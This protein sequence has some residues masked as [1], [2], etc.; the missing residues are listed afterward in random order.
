M[1]QEKFVRKRA[2]EG[3]RAL[4]GEAPFIGEVVVVEKGSQTQMT[5]ERRKDEQE[6]NRTA[7]NRGER[8]GFKNRRSVR[9]ILRPGSTK[10]GLNR[11][12]V[13]RV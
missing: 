10:C 5:V 11:P 6:R 7:K 13:A 12:S 4:V 8:N 3:L 1:D 2:I 9:A